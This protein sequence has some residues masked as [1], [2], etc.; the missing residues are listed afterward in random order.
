MLAHLPESPGEVGRG[1]CKG[2]NRSVRSPRPSSYLLSC[3]AGWLCSRAGAAVVP[4]GRPCSGLCAGSGPVRKSDDSRCF[5]RRPR[6]SSHLAPCCACGLGPAASARPLAGVTP[7]RSQG[8]LGEGWETQG[9][10]AGR[11]T[12][13]GGRAG[14]THAYLPQSFSGY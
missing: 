1:W 11:C 2:S 9:K 8:L 6:R 13:E 3:P 12:R 7:V 10:L 5:T 4:K 14:K